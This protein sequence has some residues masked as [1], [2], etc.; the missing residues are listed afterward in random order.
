[1]IRAAY[2]DPATTKYQGRFRGRI[3]RFFN[4]ICPVIEEYEDKTGWVDDLSS[5]DNA[6]NELMSF[7]TDNGISQDSLFN[8]IRAG[9]IGGLSYGRSHTPATGRQIVTECFP[10]ATTGKAYENT[11]TKD[12]QSER[13]QTM[14]MQYNAPIFTDTQAALCSRTK[15]PSTLMILKIMMWYHS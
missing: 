14:L 1:M 12:R 2:P 9:A 4:G 8:L 6:Y 15:M 11:A 5:I 7:F 3:Y 10:E 13:L